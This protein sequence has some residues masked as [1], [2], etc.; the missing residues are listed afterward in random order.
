MTDIREG[1]LVKVR[2]YTGGES[3]VDS[4]PTEASAV[5]VARRFNEA[6]QTDTYYVEEYD[7]EKVQWPSL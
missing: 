7:K 5:D 2:R 6:Y 4:C 1:W 3:V